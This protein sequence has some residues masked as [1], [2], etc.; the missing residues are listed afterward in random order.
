M[1]IVSSPL[2]F[3]D[4]HLISPLYKTETNQSARVPAADT[5]VVLRSTRPFPRYLLREK[6]YIQQLTPA[7][8]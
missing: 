5:P 6:D 2:V 3:P 8:S 4:S 1:F 7:C